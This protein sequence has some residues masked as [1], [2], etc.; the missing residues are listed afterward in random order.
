MEPSGLTLSTR[1]PVLCF[2]CLIPYLSYPFP[3]LCLGCLSVSGDSQ[4]RVPAEVVNR[5]EPYFTPE[6]KATM[7]G[8][9]RKEMGDEEAAAR[10]V[11]HKWKLIAKKRIKADAIDEQVAIS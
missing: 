9:E 4:A 2:T 6:F 8:E 10:G 7:K 1:S 11:E 5:L 3:V